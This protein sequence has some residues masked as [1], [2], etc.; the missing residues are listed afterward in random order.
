MAMIGADVRRSHRP[1]AGAERCIYIVAG[2]FH[3]PAQSQ[4]PTT[5]LHRLHHSVYNFGCSTIN[6]RSCNR[7][8]LDC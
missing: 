7:T 6:P 2:T 8:V 4:I 1:E 3:R 5:I